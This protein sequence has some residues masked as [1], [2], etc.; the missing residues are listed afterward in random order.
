[1]TDKTC[2]F[3]NP[4]SISALR[5]FISRTNT[6]LLFLLTIT[7]S[8]INLL[9]GAWLKRKLCYLRTTARTG[10]VALMHLARKSTVASA[11][12]ISS[13]SHF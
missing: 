6:L 3:K 9:I 13:R 11:I 8:A 2:Q 10:P 7:V 12:L 1:M 4:Q 5:V